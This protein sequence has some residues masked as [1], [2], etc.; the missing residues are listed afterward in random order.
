MNKTPLFVLA[1]VA[2]AGLLFVYSNQSAQLETDVNLANVV[3]T[4]VE[5]GTTAMTVG[6]DILL[7]DITPSAGDDA[8]IAEDVA[9]DEDGMTE[10]EAVLEEDGD[11]TEGD[12]G[13]D[14]EDM[15]VEDEEGESVH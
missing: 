10:E 9:T 4:S 15:P 7:E 3:D 5:A 12:E 1:A 8:N 11:M 2:V 6:E 13:S 14:A